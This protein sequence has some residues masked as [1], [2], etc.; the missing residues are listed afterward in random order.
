[1]MDVVIYHVVEPGID[2]INVIS[3]S[4]GKL[5]K[6]FDY[7][8]G[9]LLF[10]YVQRYCSEFNYNIINMDCKNKDNRCDCLY[11]GKPT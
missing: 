9:K 6:L 11:K 3:A 5:L 8:Y 10:Q 7:N 4:S 1:M 2:S